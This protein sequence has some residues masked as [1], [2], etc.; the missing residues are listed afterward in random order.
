VH[1]ILQTVRFHAG[2]DLGD[3]YGTPILSSNCGVV[4]EAGPRGGYGQYTC[5][6]HG[7]GLESCYAHQSEIAVRAGQEVQK[8]EYIGKVGS[9]GL[10]T[11][12]HLHFE[13]REN[14]VP[15]DPTLY[16]RF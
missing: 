16:V 8:G 1:P 11:G 2:I 6:S 14:N 12:P 7:K 15:R 5:I 9:T 3:P 4:T 13:I 10:S